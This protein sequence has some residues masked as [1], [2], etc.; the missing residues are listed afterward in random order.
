MQRGDAKRAADLLAIDGNGELSVA[1]EGI[2]G[3]G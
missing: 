2:L 3:K 1:L